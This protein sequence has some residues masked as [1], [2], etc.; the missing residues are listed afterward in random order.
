MLRAVIENLQIEVVSSY[1]AGGTTLVH[2]H[3][4]LWSRNLRCYGL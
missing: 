1:T 3:R 2:W 4:G